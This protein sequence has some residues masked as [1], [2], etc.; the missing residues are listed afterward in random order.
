MGLEVFLVVLEVNPGPMQQ[1]DYV[2]IFLE[3]AR[4]LE[5]AL[6]WPGVAGLFAVAVDLAEQH[7]RDMQL[8]LECGDLV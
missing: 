7:D 2:S 3:R 8:F 1:H 6:G 4:V 5:V